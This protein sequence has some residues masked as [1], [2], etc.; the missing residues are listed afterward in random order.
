M[1]YASEIDDVITSQNPELKAAVWRVSSL[2]HFTYSLVL[3]GPSTTRR[4]R[5]LR[6]AQLLSGNL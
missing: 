5:A 3:G 4:E 1:F 6:V 2:V